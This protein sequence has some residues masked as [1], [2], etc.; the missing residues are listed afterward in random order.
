MYVRCHHC[1]RRNDRAAL[2]CV[3]CGQPLPSNLKHSF[4][5]EN[6]RV[7]WLMAG[8][9]LFLILGVLTA[10]HFAPIPIQGKY[11]GQAVVLPP[12]LTNDD[13]SVSY[14]LQQLNGR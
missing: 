9:I 14:S 11:P 5:G 6:A 8:I 3:A 1:R 10:Q 12:T 4:L 2:E 7:F 13:D